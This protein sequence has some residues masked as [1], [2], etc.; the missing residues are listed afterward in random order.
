MFDGI[1]VGRL[2]LQDAGLKCA[3]YLASEVD[4][5]ASHV[6]ARNFPDIVH[7]GCVKSLN[8]VDVVPVDLLMGGPPCQELS[9]AR[10]GLGLEGPKSRLL[11][12]YVEFKNLLKPKYFLMENVVPRKREWR[13]TIDRA[14]GVVG[15][16]INSDLFVP[17]NRERVYWTNI[18]IPALP[19]RPSWDRPTCRY[20]NIDGFRWMKSGVSACLTARMGTGGGNI[21]LKSENRGDALTPEECEALQGLPEGYTSG[22]PKTQRY[23]MIGNSWTAPVVSHILTGI[24]S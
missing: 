3:R 18:P 23:K 12:R 4:T 15:V 16:S 11:M 5:H 14:L 22:T 24:R 10:V 1:G 6:A 8:W 7:L 2:A 9:N 21:P 20:R 17:Q 13:D 19:P